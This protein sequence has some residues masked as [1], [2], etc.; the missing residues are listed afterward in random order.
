MI[1]LVA[2]NKRK[3]YYAFLTQPII[4]NSDSTTQTEVWLV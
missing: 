4:H 2:C 3:E 1:L